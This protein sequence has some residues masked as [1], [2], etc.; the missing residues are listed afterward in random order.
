MDAEPKNVDLITERVNA[1]EDIFCEIRDHSK[2][3][4]EIRRKADFGQGRVANL[5]TILYRVLEQGREP[6]S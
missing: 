1:I 6:V 4:F 2:T 5:K 3:P